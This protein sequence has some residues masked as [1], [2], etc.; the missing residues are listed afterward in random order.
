M[1][2][3]DKKRFIKIK[4]FNSDKIIGWAVLLVT[5]FKNHRQFGDMLG[6][7]IVD[8]FAETGAEISI[9]NAAEF[10]FKKEAK[11]DLILTNQ[12]N[13]NWCDAFRR[14]G[15]LKGP[16]NYI[17]FCSKSLSEKLN[18]L[19]S[20]KDFTHFNRGDGDGPINL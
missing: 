8:N 10:Y 3:K 9:I 6:G 12:S 14:K 15:F 5:R 18:P 4:V 16:S 19:H 11:V 2:G 13:K 20:S 1:Y 17:F 7:T